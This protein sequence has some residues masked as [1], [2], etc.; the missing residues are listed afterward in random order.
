VRSLDRSWR[1]QNREVVTK[2]AVNFVTTLDG[3]KALDKKTH[4]EQ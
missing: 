3:M 2:M 1:C 4:L